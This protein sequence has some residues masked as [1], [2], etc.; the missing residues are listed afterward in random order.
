MNPNLLILLFLASA[1]IADS[2]RDMEIQAIFPDVVYL[3]VEYDKLFRIRNLDHVTGDTDSIDVWVIYNVSSA[4][5]YNQQTFALTGLNKEKTAGTGSVT[6]SAPGRYIICG[7]IANATVH[8]PDTAN[9]VACKNVSAL[10]STGL[11][12]NVSIGLETGKTVYEADEVVGFYNRLSNES[13][14]YVIEYWA[15]DLFGNLLKKKVNTSNTNKKTFTPNIEETDRVI[16]FMNRIAYIACNNS[17]IGSSHKYIFATRAPPEPYLQISKVD[18]PGSDYALFGSSFNAEIVLSK[19]NST[20]RTLY[21]SVEGL[22]ET[23]KAYIDDPLEHRLSL[24]VRLKGGCDSPKTNGQYTLVAKGFDLSDEK[25]IRIRMPVCE[26]PDS[27]AKG[28][29]EV[30]LVNVP[31]RVAG[32][33]YAKVNITNRYSTEQLF[34]VYSYAYRGSRSY[35]GN[36]TENLE[37]VKA[38]SGRSVQVRQRVELD[39]DP[40]EYKV[41]AVVVRKGYKTGKEAVADFEVEGIISCPEL[42]PCECENMTIA[43]KDNCSFVN[44]SYPAYLS[45][46]G[47]ARDLVPYFMAGAF[48]VLS[49]I[50]LK[51][52]PV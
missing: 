50:L 23:T 52:N 40:G 49:L 7:R 20:K 2:G 9:N 4:E 39:A 34:E 46:S 42:L 17:G 21:L 31:K 35:S 51:K 24:P 25:K 3:N 6:F 41:K 16:L 47:K 44:G 5:S 13:Y 48:A 36:R 33:F 11:A 8:D 19:G 45:A 14:Y 10:D 43:V 26:K 27:V 30:S 38:G 32:P 22:S 29:F 28:G 18:Y 37:T 12:C 15:E 1:C